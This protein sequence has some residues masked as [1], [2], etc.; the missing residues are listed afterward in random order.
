MS[1]RFTV[2][3]ASPF[4]SLFYPKM[5]LGLESKNL[6]FE[7]RIFASCLSW[8]H[9]G[10]RESSACS[11]KEDQFM[12]SICVVGVQWGDEGKGKVIDMM[13][14]SSDLVVR[15]SGGNNAGHTVVVGEDKFVLHLLP[16]GILRPETKNLIGG[17]VVVDPWELV[18][19]IEGIRKLG[20]GVELGKNLFL[21]WT[22]HLILPYHRMQDKVMEELRGHGKIGTTGRGIGPAYQDR[23]SR[24][25]LRFSDLA[26][27][28]VLEKRVDAALSFKNRFLEGLGKPPI[29][30]AQLLA[31][32]QEVGRVLLPGGVDVGAEV[33]KAA[34]A[35]K[36]ILFE[37]AQGMM[38]DVDLGTYPYVTS[39]SVG[40]AGI[41]TA[42]FPPRHVQRVVG[43][44][45]A[46]TT[47]VGEGPFPTELLDDMG[48]KIRTQGNEFGATTGRPRRCGWFDLVAT[49]YAVE[50][51]GVDQLCVTNLDVLSGISPLKVAVAYEGPTK[52]YEIFPAGVPGFETLEARYVELEGWNEDLTSVR[53]FEELPSAARAYVEFL[54]QGLGIAIPILSV[55]PGRKQVIH[56]GSPSN[57]DP[58]P[59][60]LGV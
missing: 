55:G 52:S 19:E 2:Y 16:S 54:E 11:T 41:G 15:Y 3:T 8:E 38:L 21:S 26:D 40:P 1:I 44:A 10:R 60:V 22:A 17:G 37:G 30:R 49:R 4:P 53:T 46:Y 45:K 56:R 28:A 7:A 33:R 36:E 59:K 23:A 27:A 31:D 25:G 43:V 42:G 5:A 57:K 39:S 34:L 13:S 47:R 12:S 35:K 24:I 48:E 14:A 51:A 6:R 50:V 32:L 58:S 9:R 20:I 18:R 29:D